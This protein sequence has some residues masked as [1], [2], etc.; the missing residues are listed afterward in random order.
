[1]DCCVIIWIDK[2][3]EDE[4]R[5][6]GEA[7]PTK[8]KKKKR[9][10]SPIEWDRQSGERSEEEPEEEEEIKSDDNKS[11]KSDESVQRRKGY[12]IIN[13][14]RVMGDT[15][16]YGV[17]VRTD[18]VKL[19]IELVWNNTHWMLGSPSNLFNYGIAL[20]NMWSYLQTDLS[21]DHEVFF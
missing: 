11:D 4:I 2:F 12:S 13:H 9:S 18:L 7:G 16:L 21:T 5:S 15:F 1:M 14:I 8:R 20:S 17:G 6:D 19:A 3:S 10:I